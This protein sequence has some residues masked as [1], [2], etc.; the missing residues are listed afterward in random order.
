MPQFMDDML[1]WF[2]LGELSTG[3]V[4]FQNAFYAIT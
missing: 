4:D 3:T 2:A 1:F